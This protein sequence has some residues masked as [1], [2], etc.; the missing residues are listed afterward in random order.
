MTYGLFM[1]CLVPN[2]YPGIEWATE[3]LF[4]KKQLNVPA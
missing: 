3:Y 4:D 2:R 1:G